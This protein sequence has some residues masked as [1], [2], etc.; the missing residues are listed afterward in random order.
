MLATDGIW[1]ERDDSAGGN[2]RHHGITIRMATVHFTFSVTVTHCPWAHPRNLNTGLMCETYLNSTFI[3]HPRS[4]KLKTIKGYSG[5]PLPQ[6]LRDI[7]P[8]CTSPHLLSGAVLRRLVAPQKGA[9]PA[10]AHFSGAFLEGRAWQRARGAVALT[11]IN[12]L[13]D[14]AG[15]GRPGALPL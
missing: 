2:Y 12:G 3:D 1:I 5:S 10:W 6:R 7:R 9:Q 4:K 11:L 13:R 15:R 8:D 14:W